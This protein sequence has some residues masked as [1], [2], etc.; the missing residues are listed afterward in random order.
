MMEFRA[1]LSTVIAFTPPVVEDAEAKAA[2]SRPDAALVAD[3]RAEL[4]TDTALSEPDAEEPEGAG[5]GAGTTTVV[6]PA[7]LAV[8]RAALRTDMALSD[9]DEEDPEAA[10]NGTGATTAVVPVLP[11]GEEAAVCWAAEACAAAGGDEAEGTTGITTG[12]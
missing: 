12:I 9:P 6:V 5:T 7:L 2:D 8:S 3:C 1:E 11:V 10:G 4:S